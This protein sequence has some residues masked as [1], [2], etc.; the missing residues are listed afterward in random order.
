[1]PWAPDHL[2]SSVAS[3][4]EPSEEDEKEER[5]SSYK[6]RNK[7]KPWPEIH[8]LKLDPELSKSSYTPDIQT[9]EKLMEREAHKLIQTAQ[10]SMF[11]YS[12]HCHS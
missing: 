3:G 10:S 8:S 7:W 6:Q 12:Y 2:D 5:T 11:V 9:S 4:R 1:M